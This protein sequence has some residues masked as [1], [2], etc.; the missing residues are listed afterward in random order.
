M[1]DI[2]NIAD[3]VPADKVRQALENTPIITKDDP[4]EGGQGQVY[5]IHVDGQFTEYSRVREVGDDNALVYQRDGVEHECTIT[6]H[7]LIINGTKLYFT[8]D[9]FK[10]TMALNEDTLLASD[11]YDPDNEE[12]SSLKG[13]K[14]TQRQSN[15]GQRARKL[16]SPQGMPKD[17]LLL[18]LGAGAAIGIMIMQY[19]GMA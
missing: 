9:G 12:I 10:G 8:R 5:L 18:A 7:P 6:S 3:K 2:M 15:K 14:A 11:I 4:V 17:Q 16:L 13:S 19:G 1:G